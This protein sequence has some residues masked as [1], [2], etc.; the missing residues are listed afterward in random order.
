LTTSITAP[1]GGGARQYAPHRLATVRDLA[2]RSVAGRLAAATLA[3]AVLDAGFAVVTDIGVAGRYNFETLLQYIATG[4]F[5]H[6]AYRSGWDGVGTATL[7]F[8][9]HVALA[10]AFATAFAVTAGPRLRT[11]AVLIAAGLTYGVGVWI[12]MANAVLP[13]LGVAHEPIA[14]GYWW[15]FLIDHAL[16]VGLPISLI[17]SRRTQ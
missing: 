6:D 10:G 11:Q 2:T 8:A 12:L 14:S 5:G 15:A 13:V 4:L 7:G 1:T 9:T 3:A 17:T 16:L